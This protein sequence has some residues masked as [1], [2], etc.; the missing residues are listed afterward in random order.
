MVVTVD[1]NPK[2]LRFGEV[3]CRRICRQYVG[4]TQCVRPTYC[5]HT[6]QHVERAHSPNGTVPMTYERGRLR[7]SASCCEIDMF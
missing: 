6:T 3:T 2:S 5:L 7:K 1:P 4:R